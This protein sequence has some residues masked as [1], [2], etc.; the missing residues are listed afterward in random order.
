MSLQGYYRNMSGLDIHMLHLGWPDSEDGKRLQ[1]D[2]PSCRLFESM[3]PFRHLKWLIQYSTRR[4]VYTT[5][6]IPIAA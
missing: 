1:L 4:L 2:N 6:Q 5:I 3:E